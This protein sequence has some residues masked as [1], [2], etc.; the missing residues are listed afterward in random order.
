MS[1][2]HA[3]HGNNHRRQ[4]RK[5]GRLGKRLHSMLANHSTHKLG[6][7]R[8]IKALSAR[9]A[10]VLSNNMKDINRSFLLLGRMQTRI[11]LNVLGPDVSSINLQ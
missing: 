3:S 5:F 1:K 7:K 11:G 10:A 6:I 2:I 9:L 8:P 4:I